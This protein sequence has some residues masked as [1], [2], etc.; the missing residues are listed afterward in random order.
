MFDDRCGECVLGP[1][2]GVHRTLGHVCVG[3]DV[4]EVDQAVGLHCKLACCRTDDLQPRGRGLLVDYLGHRHSPPPFPHLPVHAR[5]RLAA[6]K[7]VLVPLVSNVATDFRS[8]LGVLYIPKVCKVLRVMTHGLMLERAHAGRS[9]HGTA[10]RRRSLAGCGASESMRSHGL[11]PQTSS[12]PRTLY[13]MFQF[14]AF[15]GPHDHAPRLVKWPSEDD[16]TAG[17]ARPRKVPA[18]PSGGH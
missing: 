2:V 12:G 17:S 7:S 3:E 5:P 16:S 8:Y 6:R 11:Q 9:W 13:E 1:E 14:V 4:V 18:R 10:C 15:R